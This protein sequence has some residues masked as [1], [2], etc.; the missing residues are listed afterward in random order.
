[1]R[2]L[3]KYLSDIRFLLP[4]AFLLLFE[5]FMQSGLYAF[6]LE[7][8]SYAENVNSVVR[9]IRRSKLKPNVLVLGTSVA[10][11]GINLPLLNRLVNPYGLVV[12]SGATEGAMLITQHMIFKTVKPVLPDL[13]LII[14]VSEVTFPWTVRDTIDEPNLSM[15][16]QLNRKDAIDL[17]KKYEYKLTSHEY[18]YLLIRSI[19]YRRDMRDFVLSPLDR[20]KRIG[21]KW[22]EPYSDFPYENRNP[23][24]MDAYPAKTLAECIAIAKKGVSEFDQNGKRITDRMHRES[25]WK[26]CELGKYDPMKERGGEQWKDLYFRQFRIFLN[27]LEKDRLKVVTVFPPYSSLIHDLN[28][29]GRSL[30]WEK[31]LKEIHGDAPYFVFDLRDS[32]DGPENSSYYYDTIHLNRR[33][34]L[35]FTEHLARELIRIAPELL[36]T[37]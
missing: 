8:K 6:L 22:N 20:L 17:L 16:A 35:K 13:K 32:L 5:L 4:A 37:N 36:R 23:Y 9:A 31:K 33:G 2:E 29:K 34:S 15:L 26:T 19:A 28:A 30:V 21:R 11:Q 14:H 3:R 18:S 7:P 1:M 12:Q 27:E 25:V 24:G 10:Y